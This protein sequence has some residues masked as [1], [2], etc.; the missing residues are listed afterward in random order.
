MECGLTN[1]TI[2]SNVIN[3]GRGVFYNCARLTGVYFLGNA[4]SSVGVDL[5]YGATNVTV[6]YLP[7]STGWDKTF[8]GRPTAMWTGNSP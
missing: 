1:A 6:Y 3:L 7:G 4:P 2:G 8:G 5:F